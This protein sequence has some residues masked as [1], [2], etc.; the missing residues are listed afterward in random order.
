MRMINTFLNN[1]RKSHEEVGFL[2]VVD[3][4]GV[5]LS[6]L[7]ITVKELKNSGLDSQ[8]IKNEILPNFGFKEGSLPIE[9]MEE[10]Q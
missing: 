4:D 5:S 6:D 2:G 7:L 10:L 9:I 8:F 1:I 3:D